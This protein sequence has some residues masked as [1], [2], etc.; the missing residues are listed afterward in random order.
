MILP[1][2]GYLARELQHRQPAKSKCS[3]E[4]DAINEMTETIPSERVMHFARNNEICHVLQSGRQRRSPLW[5]EIWP[6][7]LEALHVQLSDIRKGCNARLSQLYRQVITMPQICFSH[8]WWILSS[9]SLLTVKFQSGPCVL[10]TNTAPTSQEHHRCKH[11]K[12]ARPSKPT[13]KQCM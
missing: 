10:R 2:L 9:L 5:R 3:S 11:S 13:S 7:L 6:V 4:K 8:W 1:P 12:P